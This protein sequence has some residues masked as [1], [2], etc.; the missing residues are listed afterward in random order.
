MGMIELKRI[1]NNYSSF[2]NR[3]HDV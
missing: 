1:M 2:D 3:L